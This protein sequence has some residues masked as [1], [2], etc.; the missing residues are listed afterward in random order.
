[1]KAYARRAFTLVELLVVIT[2]IGILIALLLPAVQ[3]AR[4]AARGAQ[5]RNNMKQLALGLHNYLDKVTAFPPAGF[6]GKPG[7]SWSVYVL[8]SLEQES[9]Y[10][11][12]D[13]KYWYSES[14][15]Y[16]PT[17]TMVGA[18]YCPSG[19][20]TVSGSTW[21]YYSSKYLPA[22]H[23]AAVHGPKGT[24]PQTGAAYPVYT[25]PVPSGQSAQGNCATSGILYIDSATKMADITDG[26]STTFLLGELSW[27]DSAAYRVWTRGWASG[28]FIGTATFSSASP[29][30]NV[31]YGIN[32]VPF[33][34]ANFN[35]VSFGS[36]HPRGTHF[37]MAD[38]AVRFVQET[39]DMTVYRA[40]ASR[41]QDEAKQLP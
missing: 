6:S 28:T 16:S 14:P 25:V 22:M 17:T 33:T 9:L 1:M 35:D 26:T 34:G 11:R 19:T 20:V 27:K 38:G 36:Q 10:E 37:A 39:I 29:G 18:Y 2:I 7:F 21:D 5:C 32:L 23:Y 8:P 15:N 31:A 24:N 30:R 13:C 40:I 41:N 3:A 12:F 4:E